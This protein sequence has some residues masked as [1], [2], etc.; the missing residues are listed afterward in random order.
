M[1]KHK[2]FDG[3][4][5]VQVSP[6]MEEFTTHLDDEEAHGIGTQKF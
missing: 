3:T 4:K 6:S 5:M 2:Y 1:A